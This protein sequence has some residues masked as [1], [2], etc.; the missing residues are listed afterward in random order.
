VSPLRSAT[1]VQ[2]FVVRA[3][4]YRIVLRMIRAESPKENSPG[5]AK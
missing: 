2:I 3:R 1:A 5:Q 4:S